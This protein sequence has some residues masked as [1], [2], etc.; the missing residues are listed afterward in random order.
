MVE[1]STTTKGRSLTGEAAKLPALTE[2]HSFPVQQFEAG[3]ARDFSQ[4]LGTETMCALL[5]SIANTLK[6]GVAALDDEQ[7][8]HWQFNWVRGEEPPAGTTIRTND[9]KRLW[10]PV[11][12][13]DCTATLTVYIQESAAL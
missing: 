4:E 3:I 6:T 9:G 11:T 8:A 1:A 2:T 7:E 5:G 12:V 13:R 10:F